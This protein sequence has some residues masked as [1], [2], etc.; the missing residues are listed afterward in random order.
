ML[1]CCPTETTWRLPWMLRRAAPSCCCLCSYFTAVYKPHQQHGIHSAGEVHDA[2]ALPPVPSVCRT[3]WRPMAS[4]C[5]RMRRCGGRSWRR[6][7][8]ACRREPR[9]AW[10]MASPIGSRNQAHPRLQSPRFEYAALGLVSSAPAAFREPPHFAPLKNRNALALKPAP[11]THACESVKWLGR[12]AHAVCV[13][14]LYV[15]E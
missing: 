9:A 14:N 7:C 4:G 12:E 8:R 5:P 13:W 6:R 11:L 3:G 1:A 2:E 15:D 10:L